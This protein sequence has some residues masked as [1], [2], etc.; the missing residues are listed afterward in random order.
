M[1]Y[2]DPPLA[3]NVVESR[4]TQLQPKNK[5]SKASQEKSAEISKC[6]NELIEGFNLQ[7]EMRAKDP[8][9]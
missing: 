8:H 1:M 2:N 4:E 7:N 3:K 5:A 9:G 6:P